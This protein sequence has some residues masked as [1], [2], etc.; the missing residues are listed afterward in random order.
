M[1]GGMIP[2]QANVN[3]GTWSIAFASINLFD[4]Q[5][6]DLGLYFCNLKL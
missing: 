5:S 3:Y 4:K 2:F 1:G 6:W